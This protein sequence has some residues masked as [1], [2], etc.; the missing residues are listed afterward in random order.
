M[1]ALA[2]LTMLLQYPVAKGTVVEIPRSELVARR[3]TQA[4]IEKGK[5]CCRSRGITCR[6]AED[7]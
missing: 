4:D 3:Y 7:K 1:C 2:V 5:R 6:V